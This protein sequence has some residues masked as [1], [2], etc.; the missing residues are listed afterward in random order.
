M[1]EI[2]FFNHYHRGDLHTH[3]EFVRQIKQEI[4]DKVKLSYLHNNP[5]KLLEDLGI[6]TVGSPNFLDKQKPLLKQ[7]ETIYVNTWVGSQW[8][9][10][11]KNGGINMDT[12]YEQ[13]GK[14]FYGISKLTGFEIKLRESKESYLPVVD[15]S[16]LNLDA[17]DKYL[18]GSKG[19]KKVLICNNTPNSSQSFHANMDQ[20]IIDIATNN[21]EVHFIC[22]NEV[23]A[24]LPNI[25]YTSE[26]IQNTDSC[27]LQEI[28]YLST[29][30]DSIIGKNSGPFVFCETY[31]NY[32]DASK[33]FFSFNTKHPDY[34]DVKETMS[35]NLKLKC[36]YK[37]TPI[38]DIV[39][40][41]PTDRTNIANALSEAVK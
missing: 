31:D 39:S 35:Y 12:L 37:A 32:M 27:D 10:F 18:E 2:V 40:L 8:D 7:G 38:Q 4:G 20:F 28:S 34:D 21:P 36:S 3:K 25:K 30:C 17:T 33:K 6:E 9:V 24:E 19:V 16:I 5:P 41:S 11:C 13:W 15:Y 26:I 22:T 1:S 29:F 14:L 23:E